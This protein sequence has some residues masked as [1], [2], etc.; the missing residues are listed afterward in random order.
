MN[1]LSDF[2]HEQLNKYSAYIVLLFFYGVFA[3]NCVNYLFLSVSENLS[4]LMSMLV[5]GGFWICFMRVYPKFLKYYKLAFSK[6]VN[7]QVENTIP[8]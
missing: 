3:Y 4:A 5:L 7:K 8:F 6:S 2:E 1:D